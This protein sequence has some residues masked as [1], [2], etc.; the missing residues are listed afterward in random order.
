MLSASI[1][2]GSLM[3]IKNDINKLA[4][5]NVDML[6]VDIMDGHFVPNITFGPDMVNE[7]EQV[8]RI[9]LDIHIM[10]EQPILVLQRM[11]LSHRDYV[12]IHA[13]IN[14]EEIEKAIRYLHENR[15]RT[16][17]ALNPKTDFEKIEKYL[18]D[19]D[20]ILFMFVEPGF[21]GAR[22][23]PKVI[24]KIK[25]ARAFLEEHEYDNIVLSVDGGISLERARECKS[26]GVSVF[27]GGTSSIYKKDSD[28]F[29]NI[30]NFKAEI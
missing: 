6:H 26:N 22:P 10:A 20:M 18:D 27:V 13:E 1:M 7:L 16:G 15:I 24:N 9:P 12:T 29:E 3:D 25:H 23:V 11:H 21:A 5:A 8:S 28:I 14:D 17:I 30:K 4:D 2:C 19:I